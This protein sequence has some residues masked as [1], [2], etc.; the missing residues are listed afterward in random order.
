MSRPLAWL[1]PR[2]VSTV[3]TSEKARLLVRA[4]RIAQLRHPNLVR[5]LPM[6]GGAGLAPRSAPGRRLSDFTPAG[7]F[8]RFELEQVVRLLLDVLSGLSALHEDIEDGVGFVHGEVSPQHIYLGPDGTA[9]LVPLLSRHWMPEP[10]TISNG[11]GAPEFLMSARVDPRA[12]LFSVGVMLGEA[13]TGK[14]LFPDP[15][16]DAVLVRLLGGKVLPIL[17]ADKSRWALPLCAIAERA[18]SPYPE[19]RFRSAI[20]LSNAIGAA[21]GARLA[22][23]EQDGWH[24]EAPTLVHIP[25]PAVAALRTLTP[26]ATVL[27]IEPQQDSTQPVSLLQP[28]QASVA[29]RHTARSRRW[30]VSLGAGAVAAATLLLP[31]WPTHRPGSV[32]TAASRPEFA[33]TAATGAPSSASNVTASPSA[34]ASVASAGLTPGSAASVA[35]PLPSQGAKPPARA[36]PRDSKSARSREDYGI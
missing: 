13:L 18:I 21:I 16:L 1:H 11:Y 14:P 24:A 10:P 3:T 34:P 20:E 29:G 36:R 15:S 22:E 25:R 33:F 6:P 2:S 27:D 5:M 8:K 19:L 32:S 23:R 7:T 28:D 30:L 35:P 4:Q 12:D 26:F 31:W 17:P 9:R